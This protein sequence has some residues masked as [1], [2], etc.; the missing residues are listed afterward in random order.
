M[1]NQT[2]FEIRCEWGEAGVLQ[3]APISDVIIIVDVLSFSTCVEVATRR[4]AV[5]YPYRGD[6][7]TAVTYAA[8][9]NATLASRRG[10]AG[11]TLSPQSL[12]QIPAGTRLVLP[13]PNG[14]ALTLSTGQTPTLA[15]CW[16]NYRAVAAAAQR[17]G[18]HIAVVPAGERWRDGSLRPSFEDWAGAGAIISCLTGRHSPDAQA[19]RATFL[20]LQ[21][22]LPQLLFACGSGQ[23][24]IAEGFTEDVALAAAL[25]VSDC[26]P[27]LT[28]GVYQKGCFC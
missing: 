17:F 3:L 26:V 9:L 19:A 23:E 11:Y 28:Q 15:G 24:L 20:S 13:S 18:R 22:S 7:E 27:V 12:T 21:E 8:S 4:G 2:Q 25:D 16:R 14:S 5:V 10:Q 1:F 6:R